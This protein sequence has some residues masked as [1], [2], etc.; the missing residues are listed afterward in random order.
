MDG[1]N[2]CAESGSRNSWLVHC[3][4]VEQAAP[5]GFRQDDIETSGQDSFAPST[6]FQKRRV[7][8]VAREVVESDGDERMVPRR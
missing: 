4:I 7:D 3:T 8:I 6:Q 5:Q 1:K 2:W